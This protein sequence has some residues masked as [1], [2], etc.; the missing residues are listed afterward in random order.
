M[1]LAIFALFIGAAAAM[2]TQS[3]GSIVASKLKEELN[4][5]KIITDEEGKPSDG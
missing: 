3:T 4:V 5:T 1:K 2:R